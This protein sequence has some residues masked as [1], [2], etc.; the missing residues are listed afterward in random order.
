MCEK[1]TQKNCSNIMRTLETFEDDRYYYIVTEYMQAGDLYNYL[2][3]LHDQPISEEHTKS[4]L[5]QLATAVD[6]LHSHNI[7]HRDIK[8]EN[9]LVEDFSRMTSL[10]LADFGL[11]VQLAS[12]TEKINDVV[13]TNGYIAPEILQE[14]SYSFA[15]DVYSLG[16]TIYFLLTGDHPFDDSIHEE[17]IRKVIEDPLDLTDNSYTDNLSEPLKNLLSGMLEKDPSKRLTVK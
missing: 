8:I 5:K 3:N 15:A 17:M 1:V 10:K 14:Q 11:A 7:L 9:V 4:V 16:A 12:P 6:V 2:C 13:G